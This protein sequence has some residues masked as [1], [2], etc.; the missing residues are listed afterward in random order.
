MEEQAQSWRQRRKKALGALEDLLP[1][2]LFSLTFPTT[3]I[4]GSWHREGT[5]WVCQGEE[6][7][8]P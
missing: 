7:G 1:Y 2:V 6:H 3:D 5:G 4:H 8:G